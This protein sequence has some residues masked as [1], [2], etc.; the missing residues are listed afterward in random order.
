M[1]PMKKIVLHGLPVERDSE[2]YLTQII[3]RLN[4][5]GVEIWYT[6]LFHSRN[7]KLLKNAENITDN[8]PGIFAI[9][10]KQGNIYRG[11][12]S[13]ALLMNTDFQNLID[14]ILLELCQL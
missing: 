10:S 2:K 9:I 6:S 8:V 11:N 4:K 3:D 13:L 7:S 12:K 14:K 1:R 5:E